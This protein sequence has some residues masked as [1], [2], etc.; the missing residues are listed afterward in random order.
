M[1]NYNQQKIAGKNLSKSNT[2]SLDFNWYQRDGLWELYV[3]HCYRGNLVKYLE[4]TRPASYRD[5]YFTGMSVPKINQLTQFNVIHYP[6]SW[7]QRINV[8]LWWYL[9]NINLNRVKKLFAFTLMYMKIKISSSF[10]V[11]P[12]QHCLFILGGILP[13]Q[14]CTLKR[15]EMKNT[16]IITKWYQI[17]RQLG[18]TSKKKGGAD[19]SLKGSRLHLTCPLYATCQVSP[20]H[21]T[22]RF[23]C[24]VKSVLYNKLL[25]I[26]VFTSVR[27][28]LSYFILTCDGRCAIALLVGLFHLHF[29]L[30]VIVVQLVTVMEEH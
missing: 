21:N 25:H 18:P 14:V 28:T 3:I 19:V 4:P 22:L 11:I 30:I 5:F 12:T 29:S 7:R 6:I 23:C 9:Q 2:L 15:E 24:T 1:C 8:V 16:A 27:F 10:E 13:F 17:Q 20:K 26:I